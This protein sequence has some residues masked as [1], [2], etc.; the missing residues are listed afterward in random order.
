MV[1][2]T[3]PGSQGD[4]AKENVEVAGAGGGG[5]RNVSEPRQAP[6]EE[7]A[8][9]QSTYEDRLLDA[10]RAAHARGVEAERRAAGRRL[11][12]RFWRGGGVGARGWTTRAVES[13]DGV[14][15]GAMGD[16]MA[17]RRASVIG[18]PMMYNNSGGWAAGEVDEGLRERFRRSRGDGG[19]WTPYGGFERA[20][21]GYG[22]FR[23]WSEGGGG[24]FV[25]IV[26]DGYGGGYG[27]Y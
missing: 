6:F 24:G 1:G 5:G 9:E 20:G 7:P 27:R 16:P 21:E 12:E 22:R 18:G 19:E 25:R 3:T 14:Y 17:W 2:G 8:V 11:Y 15:R 4:D 26:R 13:M 10:L 23:S